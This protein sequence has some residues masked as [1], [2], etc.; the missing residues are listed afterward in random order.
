MLR[1]ESRSLSAPPAPRGPLG[2][3]RAA[4]LMARAGPGQPVPVL[5][6]QTKDTSGAGPARGAAV[7]LRSA[8]EQPSQS[9]GR[10]PGQPRTGNLQ[11]ASDLPAGPAHRAA[12]LLAARPARPCLT[13]SHTR[14]PCQG[15][16]ESAGSAAAVLRGQV[17]PPIYGCHTPPSAP[18]WA[19][20]LSCPRNPSQLQ[21]FKCDHLCWPPSATPT[22]SQRSGQ[23]PGLRPKRTG[24]RRK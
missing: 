14:T 20:S 4:A 1:G 13:P 11:G 21:W 5:P 8:R 15:V 10:P 6:G 12:F 2:P 7:A 17:F 24:L 23:I 9:R 22:P 3:G 16:T 19:R 18:F